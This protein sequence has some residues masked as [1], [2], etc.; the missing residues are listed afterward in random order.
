MNTSDQ[1]HRNAMLLLVLSLI[2]FA[3][4][5][6]NGLSDA[7]STPATAKPADESASNTDSAPFEGEA[8]EEPDGPRLSPE[9][10]PPIE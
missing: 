3:A 5:V 9:D 4:L 2:A 7:Q 8:A 1:R 6:F 10:A